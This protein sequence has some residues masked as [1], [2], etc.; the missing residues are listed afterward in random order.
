MSEKDTL[1][2]VS[3]TFEKKQKSK[4]KINQFFMGV[5]S[6]FLALLGLMIIIMV[7]TGAKNPFAAAFATETPTPTNTFTA[8]PTA[9]FTE[10]PTLGPTA[11]STPSGP[12]SY[13]IKENDTCWDIA[14]A[15]GIDINVLM[16][17][18]ANM[19]CN[20]LLPGVAITIPASDAELPT[21]TPFPTDF[22]RGG[23]FIYTVQLGD[24]LVSI[25]DKFNDDYKQLMERNHI[26]DPNSIQAGDQLKV[27]YNIMTRTPTIA[28]TST[29]N[30][31]TPKPSNTPTP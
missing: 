1:K 12:Q 20:N 14:Q 7:A 21:A 3:Y 30:L 17:I 19:D 6:G 13:I 8:M 2:G 16:A 22:P 10:T 23:E 9:T 18:N 15:F 11:T 4:P 27:R 26:T 25:A 29:L 31:V 28:P 24:T 5:I